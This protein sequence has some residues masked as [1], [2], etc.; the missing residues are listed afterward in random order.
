MWT[1]ETFQLVRDGI[2]AAK[3][4]RVIKLPEKYQNIVESRKKTINKSM[5]RASINIV[6]FHIKVPPHAS[7]INTP[8]IRGAIIVLLIM[9]DF[10]L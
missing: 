1:E 3:K 2:D 4:C 5:R 10:W 8:D 6:I 9:M 7:K